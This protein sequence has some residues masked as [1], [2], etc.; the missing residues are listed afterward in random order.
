MTLGDLGGP[1]AGRLDV[2]EVRAE[3]DELVT[4]EPGDRVD[5]AGRLLEPARDRGEHLVAD[6]VTLGVVDDLE[7]VEVDEQHADAG[8]APARRGRASGAGSR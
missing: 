6:E 8:A 4:G 2:G 7:A 3:H 5:R 1:A